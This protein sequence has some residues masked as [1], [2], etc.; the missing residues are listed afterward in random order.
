MIRLNQHIGQVK[1]QQGIALIMVLLVV[2]L[3]TIITTG[4]TSKQQLSTRRTT[5]LLNNE[6]AYMYLLGAEDWARAIL[7]Q[8]AKDNKT[9]SLGDDWA[10]D[11]PAIPVEGGVIK[12]SIEDLQSRF[13]INSIIDNANKPVAENVLQLQRL[14]EA[15]NQQQNT[16][17]IPTDLDQ[18]VLD[19][20]DNNEDATTPNG[21]EDG[22]YLNKPIPYV[23]ANQ[24]MASSSELVKINRFNYSMYSEMAPYIVALPERSTLLNIN[25]ADAMQIS[26]LSKQISFS[27]AKNIVKTRSKKG[28]KTV[29]EFLDVP[30]VKDRN[31]Q[32][33]QIST[34]SSFFLLKARAI[35]GK[36]RAELYSILYRSLDGNNDAK[37]KVLLRSQRRI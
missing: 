27:Q 5:N 24:L 14:V 21:A 36:S 26:S 6:Q 12:G 25:T 23:A 34:Q 30:E 33:S 2:A 37:V 35:I 9:D 10:V 1:K 32:Q 31:V 13:N 29:D 17:S 4:I 7:V 11:L 16:I 15:I 8:D 19:W 22:A 28:Y 20:L 3:V 18:A